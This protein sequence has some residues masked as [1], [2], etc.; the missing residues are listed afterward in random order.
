MIGHDDAYDSI[1]DGTWVII[2]NLRVV[3]L[4]VP[5]ITGSAERWQRRDHLYRERGLTCRASLCCSSPL[6]PVT[7]AYGD[8]TSTI[9]SLGGAPS[10]P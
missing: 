9:T 1:F 10:R 8:T 3:S 6:P 4:A 2:D 5:V 7:G